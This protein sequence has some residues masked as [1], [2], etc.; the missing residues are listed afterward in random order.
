MGHNIMNPSSPRPGEY[1][2][3]C[4]DTSNV[5]IF[6]HKED[7]EPKRSTVVL[8]YRRNV[9]VYNKDPSSART[10]EYHFSKTRSVFVFF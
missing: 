2:L 6:T 10:G 4:S 1:H 5:S 7:F 8:S 9:R 3:S